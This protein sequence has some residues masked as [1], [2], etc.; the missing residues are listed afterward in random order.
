[1]LGLGLALG[2]ADS[3]GVSTGIVGSTLA[4]GDAEVVVEVG[5]GSSVVHPAIVKTTARAT[6]KGARR[7]RLMPPS[8]PVRPTN[9]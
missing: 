4:V 5:V 2:V 3:L 9:V 8:S 7:I 1:V 6:A